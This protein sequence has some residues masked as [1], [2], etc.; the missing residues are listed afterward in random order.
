MLCKEP[1]PPLKEVHA[2]V[3]KE[4]SKRIVMLPNSGIEN[5]IITTSNSSTLVASNSILGVPKIEGRKP[6]DK[7]SL[8]CVI[9]T[10][11]GTLEIDV[12]NFME[13]PKTSQKVENQQ[14]KVDRPI[15]HQP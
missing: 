14:P 10:S 11:L 12:G 9:V 1:L 13:S 5:P 4:E 3:K 8:W 2:Y 7:G 6:L 15:K